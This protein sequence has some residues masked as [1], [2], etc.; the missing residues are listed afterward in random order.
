[1]I[2]YADTDVC[3]HHLTQIGIHFVT[4]FEEFVL[5][6]GPKTAVFHVPFPWEGGYGDL[7]VGLVV[8]GDFRFGRLFNVEVTL[9]EFLL[10]SY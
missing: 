10:Q 1:M 7:F 9:V 6:P 4:D 5:T 8:R 2:Y 3:Q